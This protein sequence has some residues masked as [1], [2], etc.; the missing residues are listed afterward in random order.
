MRRPVTD[1]TELAALNTTLLLGLET[2]IRQFKD[3]NKMRKQ[4]DTSQFP[5]SEFRDRLDQLLSAGEKAGISITE[6]AGMLEGR[7]QELRQ[8]FAVT[9]PVESARA[10]K[11]TVVG[12]SGSMAQRVVAVLRGE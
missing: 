7:A 12:G 3:Q 9:A 4:K 1:P 6:I 2:Y 8:R 5:R 10:P 11:T